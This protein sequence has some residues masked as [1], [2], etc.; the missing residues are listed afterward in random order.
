M[1]SHEKSPVLRVRGLRIATDAGADIVQDLSFEM[2]AG[3]VLGLVGESGCGKTTTAHALLGKAR[4]GSRVVA[5]TVELEGVDLLSL[6]PEGL[7]RV[8]GERI[9]YVPQDPAA[10]LNPRQRIGAQVAEVLRVHH[11]IGDATRERI[12]E[13]FTEVG[14]PS[15]KEFLRRYPFELSGGQQQ[16][17]AI[18]MALIARPA[19]VV[20]DEP[21]TG[22]DVTTQARILELLRSL[23]RAHST[24]FVYVSHDLAVVQSLVDSLLVMYAGGAVEYADAKV[25]F[26]NPRHPYTRM[27][28]RSIPRLRTREPLSGIT[29]SA[30]APG[31][32]PPGCAFSPRCSLAVDA[33]R[34]DEP[35]YA[36]LSPGHLVRCIRPDIPLPA[37]ELVLNEPT[38][39]GDREP[40][41]GVRDLVASYGSRNHR[42]VVLHD[43]SLELAPGECLALVGESGSGKSTL[44]RCIAGLHIPDA[45][46]LLLRGEPLGAHAAKRSR[47]QRRTIQIVFQNPDRSLNPRH[48]VG[49]ILARPLA[50]FGT[51]D[52]GALQGHIKELLEKVRL[53]HT[54]I[55]R[56]P[57]ELSGGE[58]QRVAI[59]RA[60]AAQPD[61]IVCDEVTSALDVSVQAAVMSLLEELRGDGLAL[62]FITHN[63][64]LVNTVTDRVLVMNQGRVVEDAATA[65]IVSSPQHAY[66]QQ[67]LEAAPDLAT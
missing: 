28:M 11:R 49:Q 61:M 52:K 5:G 56:Y 22:L 43:V 48:T 50:L 6:S 25:A 41:L 4:S 15:D 32:R 44:G 38:V 36:E 42:V 21:T 26:T 3:E 12:C 62:L 39:A 55:N 64:A 47:E 16:R 23:S 37:L 63:L 67:L 1:S 9:S 29:G 30:P 58:K 10:S 34:T 66:T 7:R 13:T 20:L 46:A 27:L 59:A 54:Y 2:F 24:A 31:H 8:R 14:L 19:V 35:D 60:L 18:G 17:V 65:D 57:G 53:P 40:L 33:C 51:A 45:G